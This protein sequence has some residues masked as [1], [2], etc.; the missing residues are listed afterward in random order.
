MVESNVLRVS[1]KTRIIE[2][3]G[4]QGELLRNEKHLA[5]TAES[6]DEGRMNPPQGPFVPL[7]LTDP[8]VTSEAKK[9]DKGSG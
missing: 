9:N 5:N 3:K 8:P 1:G 4:E 6:E 7:K 2:I